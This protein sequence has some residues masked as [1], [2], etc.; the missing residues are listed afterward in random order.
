MNEPFESEFFN[1]LD[2]V[3]KDPVSF[4]GMLEYSMKHKPKEWIEIVRLLME[5][6]ER[7]YSNASTLGAKLEYMIDDYASYMDSGH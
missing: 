2:R 7:N 4:N 6:S 1:T 5:L 3:T